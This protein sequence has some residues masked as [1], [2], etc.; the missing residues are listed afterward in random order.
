[1]PAREAFMG[2]SW[3]VLA[4]FLVGI[5]LLAGNLAL[6]TAWLGSDRSSA[7]RGAGLAG[8]GRL[9]VRNATRHRQRS[10]LTVG[11]IAAATF[12]IVAVAA[13]RRNPAAETPEKGSGNGGFALVA[14]SSTPI[15]YDLNTASGRDKLDLDVTSP[16]TPSA[17]IPWDRLEVMAFRVRP[18]E[19]ASC[20]NLYQ[21]TLPTILGV[22]QAMIDRGG[23]KFANTPGEKPWDLLNTTLPGGKV[24]VIGDMNTL[25]YS[26]HKQVGDE[27]PVPDAAHPEYA[28]S[29]VG[30]L[31]G[32]VLQGVLL[33]SEE[34]FQRL[35]PQRA[36]Y[37]YFL[38]GD[39]QPANGQGGGEQIAGEDFQLISNTLES[40][41]APYGLD[42]EP[43][44]ERLAAFLAVQNTYL[45]TFLAL[46]GLGL[47][48]GTFG[49]ATVML[50]NVLERRAEL[51]LFRAVGFRRGGLAWLVVCENAFL[52]VWGLVAGTVSALLAMTPHLANV[53]ADV[54][55]GA[56]GML[57][58]CVFASGMA[59]ALFAVIEAVRTPILATLRG[60]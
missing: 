23:F 55:W 40:K 12:V 38:I 51:A 31:D 28:L 36:G 54:P 59:A 4:F 8:L 37:Q 35:Y 24:P 41:L 39:R 15:L 58:G 30:M 10:V 50:R 53:G 13:G 5:G 44:A 9:G 20:L 16:R 43:V 27:I 33:M 26:L 25:L 6:L 18:G 2:L 34:N 32:S 48:L 47:L 7:V 45:S 57:L 60:E 1:V 46:G 52:L 17:A 29:I 14:E 22:P 49:L 21:T 11:L 19:D 56:A 42:A 3:Y